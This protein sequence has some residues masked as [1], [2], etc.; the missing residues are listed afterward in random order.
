[1]TPEIYEMASVMSFR[2]L[3][4]DFKQLQQARFSFVEALQVL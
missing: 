4:G 3:T 2:F 1:V